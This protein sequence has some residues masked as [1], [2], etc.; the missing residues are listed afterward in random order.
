MTPAFAEKYLAVEETQWWCKARR[1]AVADLVR[2]TAPSHEVRVLEIGCSGGVLLRDLLNAGY[3]DVYGID[4]SDAAVAA[5]RARALL[6]VSAMDATRLAFQ[7]GSF[8]LVI[9]SDVLEHINDDVSALKEWRRVMTRRGTLIIFVPAF[10][11]LWSSHDE[12]NHH[13]RRYSGKQLR[14]ALELAGFTIRRASYWNMALSI[15]GFVLSLVERLLRSST[16]DGETGGL[17]EPTA[18]LNGLL[19][20][21]IAVENTALRHVNLPF[22]TSVFAVASA[23]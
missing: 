14:Q 7:D 2:R 17:V 13:V 23:S 15:P 6:N 8:D 4:I 21:L 12:A 9:A 11:M 20:R 16:R 19:H 10:Q 5:A 3:S 22:G 1:E 18:P